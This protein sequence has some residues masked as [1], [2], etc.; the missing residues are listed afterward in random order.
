MTEILLGLVIVL[1]IVNLVAL[2]LVL[3]RQREA[4][5]DSGVV[6]RL[7][8]LSAAQERSER[9]LREDLARSRAE[10]GQAAEQ[11][12]TAVERRLDAIAEGQ[13]RRAEALRSS[14]ESRLEA[15]RGDTGTKLDQ[16]KQGVEERLTGMLDQRLGESFKQ[17]AERLEQVHRG[18]GEMQS[19]AAG[20]GDLRRVLSN[21]KT[22][23]TWG[24]VQLG[25]LL[26]QMLTP[27]QFSRDVQIRP[28][29]QER[30]EFAIRLPGKEGDQ[31]VWLPIDAKFPQED[32]LR[33]VEAA[34]R[35]DPIA[36]ESAAKS[37]AEQLVTM[38]RTIKN[39]YLHPPHSTDFAIMYLPTEGL[40]AEAL[41]RPGLVESLQRDH[42]IVVAGPTTLAALIN[43]LQMGFR[44]L[45]IQKQA[46]EAW[47]V[48]GAV[49]G[50]FQKFGDVLDKLHKKLTE[51]AGTVED[52]T[53]RSRQMEK[54]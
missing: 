54:R 16:I 46:G 32:Y 38:A 34:E 12:R 14:V 20:V 5:P 35:S 41:R 21:V 43:S 52:A 49:K 8:S 44:T 13:D 11:L 50:E 28:N 51:A 19:L 40:Y 17:V 24:E 29:S 47:R 3:R 45:A 23:G 22:R 36:V 27:A 10:A 33:L 30:V 25:T 31:D 15:I 39:A 7:E 4:Q 42:R 6:P 18:L 48:L 9:G 1:G 53:H 26:E 37:L 2:I